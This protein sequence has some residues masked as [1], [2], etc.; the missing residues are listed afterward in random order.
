MAWQQRCHCHRYCM[1]STTVTVTE[2]IFVYLAIVA[3]LLKFMHRLPSQSVCGVCFLYATI[4]YIF[5]VWNFAQWVGRIGSLTQTWK[6]WFLVVKKLLL[7]VIVFY[8]IWNSKNFK[9]LVIP[10]IYFLTK[11]T[12][13]GYYWI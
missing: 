9:I 13:V 2:E 4:I 11:F 3:W 5:S 1:F 10:N 6:T 12:N 7:L 8:G